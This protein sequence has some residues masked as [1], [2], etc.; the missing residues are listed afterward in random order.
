MISVGI[1]T[2]WKLERGEIFP[3]RA[4]ADC[5]LH[6]RVREWLRLQMK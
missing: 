1:F 3:R 4:A 6:V 2:N 5:M